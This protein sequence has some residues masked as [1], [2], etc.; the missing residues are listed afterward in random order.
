M[1][2]EIVSIVFAYSYFCPDIHS[3]YK[4]FQ[5]CDWRDITR[6]RIIYH[7]PPGNRI[8]NQCNWKEIRELAQRVPFW[9]SG[10]CCIL[11]YKKQQWVVVWILIDSIFFHYNRRPISSLLGFLPLG[12]PSHWCCLRHFENFTVKKILPIDRHSEDWWGSVFTGFIQ[13]AD[14]V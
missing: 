12:K 3:M 9:E 2:Y 13:P 5:R 8:R 4:P 1:I 7:S 10:F 14:V 6:C 11:K